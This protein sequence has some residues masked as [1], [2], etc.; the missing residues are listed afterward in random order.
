MNEPKTEPT[1]DGHTISDAPQYQYFVGFS[2]CF[3]TEVDLAW[4]IS[5]LQLAMTERLGW[6]MK[7]NN[8][9]L[10]FLDQRKQQYGWA[11][12]LQSKARWKSCRNEGG[13]REKRREGG[14]GTRKGTTLYNRRVHSNP[15]P[16]MLMP[17]NVLAQESRRSGRK[18]RSFGSIVTPEGAAMIYISSSPFGLQEAKRHGLIGWV[19]GTTCTYSETNCM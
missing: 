19:E 1:E 3:D 7:T 6:P 14:G 8:R 4:H 2:F 12:E 16:K 17:R 9:Q 11:G 15:T 5:L 18:R 13:K 10:L